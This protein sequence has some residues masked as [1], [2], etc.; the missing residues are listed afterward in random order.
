MKILSIDTACNTCRTALT[1]GGKIIGK[2]SETDKRTHSVKLLPAIEKI[3]K[4]AGLTP[5]DIELVAVTNGPGS[6]TGMRIGVSTAKTLAYGINAP[7]VGINTLDFLAFS[8]CSDEIPGDISSVCSLIN[9]RNERVYSC[10]YDRDLVPARECRAG[11]LADVLGELGEEGR[12]L[13]CGD[14]CVDYRDIITDKLGERAVFADEEK[15][16]GVTEVMNLLAGKIYS[17]EEDKS[18]FTP[19]K[20][21]IDYLRAYLQEK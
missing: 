21:V 3:V 13:F 15:V 8:A 1:D 6:Y 5:S 20:L 16:L 17:E 10:I 18:V 9:A 2:Y 19:E 14:G 11:D 4:E 12:V 7:L